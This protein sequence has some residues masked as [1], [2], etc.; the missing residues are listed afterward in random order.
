MRFPLAG[1]VTGGPGPAPGGQLVHARACAAAVLAGA[2][3]HLWMVSAHPHP[4]WQA[5]LMLGMAAACLPCSR[6]LWRSP[7][8]PGARM[9]MA[10]ALAMAGFHAV[11]LLAGGSAAHAHHGSVSVASG[12]LPAASGTDPG[13]LAA[14]S[15]PVAAAPSGL[16]AMLMLTAWELGAALLA[17]VWLHRRRRAGRSRPVRMGE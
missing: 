16:E 13:P 10:A 4:W 2:L 12:A 1:A 14:T 17:A 5:A 6:G 3:A 11:L 7:S 8:E 15:G 9:A